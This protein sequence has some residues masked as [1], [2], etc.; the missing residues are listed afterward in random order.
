MVRAQ[1][2]VSTVPIAVQLTS[3]LWC[4]CAA[5][6]DED[7]EGAAEEDDEDDE[8]DEEDGG[9]A[10]AESRELTMSLLQSLEHAT[11]EQHS[12]K[13]LRKLVLAFKA[14]SHM[15]D[16]QSRSRAAP[17]PYSIVSSAVFDRLLVVS[18]SHLPDVFGHHILGDASFS[19]NDPSGF[20]KMASL[21]GFKQLKPVVYRCLKALHYLLNQITD[22]SLLGFILSCLERFVPFLLPF[23]RQAKLYLKT[24]LQLWGS[25]DARN[26]KVA[27]FLRIRQLALTQPFPF[28]EHC[29]KGL[30]LTYARHAKFMTEASLPG[31]TLM[32]NCLVELYGLDMTSSYQHAFVYL[33]QL[34]LH[35]RGACTKKTKEA[36]QKVQSWQFLNCLRA[37]AAVLTAYPGADQLQ[38]LFFPLIQITLGVAKLVPSSRYY[39]LLFH[40]VNLIQRLS[41][42]AKVF[43]PCAAMLLDV[44]E[45][46]GLCKKPKASTD[47]AP[48]LHM[49][50]RLGKDLLDPK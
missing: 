42:R 6:M 9:R 5:A 50:I 44:L 45:N 32:G 27:A 36:L 3:G 37:W 15:A 26:L 43:V 30:Y 46:P 40:C 38:D 48:N 23:Q 39:P 20:A 2:H 14:A 41:A 33:R 21:P 7:E 24:L 28:I 13:A 29:L 4:C 16:E 8:D 49:A 25:N 18:L 34:A 17:G 1:S 10:P 19:A 31:L 22:P 12:Q 35:L 11:I 47:A